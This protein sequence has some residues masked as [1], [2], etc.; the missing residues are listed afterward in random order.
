M[1]F[2]DWL[3]ESATDTGEYEPGARDVDSEAVDDESVQRRLEELGY[4]E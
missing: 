3:G 1:S 4:L 2:T